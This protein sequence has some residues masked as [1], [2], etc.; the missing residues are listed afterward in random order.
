MNNET[1]IYEFQVD[2]VLC[3]GLIEYHSNQKEYKTPGVIIDNYGKIVVDKDV[4]DS[5]DVYEKLI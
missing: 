2:D 5:I 3:D 1:F 4:K